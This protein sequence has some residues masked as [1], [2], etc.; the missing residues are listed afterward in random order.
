MDNINRRFCGKMHRNDYPGKNEQKKEKDYEKNRLSCRKRF[1]WCKGYS[2]RC[3]LWS[4]ILTCGRKFPHYGA[5]Y[6]S[7]N[8]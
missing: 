8:Y 7:G 4:A 2:G 6:A 1:Y 5:E 3:I